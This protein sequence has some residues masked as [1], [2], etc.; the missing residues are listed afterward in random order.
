MI[1]YKRLVALVG[2][3]LLSTQPAYSAIQGEISATESTAVTTITLSIEPNIQISNVSDIVLDV[4]DRSQDVQFDESICV[5][6]NVGGRYSIIA[7]GEDG[8][9]SPFQL[10][11]GAGDTIGYQVYFRGDLTRI[12]GDRLSAGEASPFYEMKSQTRDCDGDNTAAFVIVF[13]SDDLLPAEP[14]IYTGFL[15]LTVEAE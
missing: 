11:S 9:N 8:G 7:A 14:G 12:A 2:L 6:G 15:T 10:T 4:T 1:G 5:R 3:A 13:K